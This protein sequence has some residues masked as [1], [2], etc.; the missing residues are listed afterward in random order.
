[1]GDLLRNWHLQ[2]DLREVRVSQ[3]VTWR[4]RSGPKKVSGHRYREFRALSIIVK[5]L[6][7]PLREVRIH[8]RALGKK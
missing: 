7:L 6:A 3:A 2:K 5:M 1:M 8:C 4:Q